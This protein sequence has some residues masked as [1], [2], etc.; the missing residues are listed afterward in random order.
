MSKVKRK[1]K[2]VPQAFKRA[3]H[4]IINSY[5]DIR[6]HVQKPMEMFKKIRSV[7][8]FPKP[9]N[10][11]VLREGSQGNTTEEKSKQPKHFVAGLVRDLFEEKSKGSKETDVKLNTI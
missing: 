11:K 1:T 7:F 9:L 5:R 2:T 4:G 3:G 8:S 10:K 6:F